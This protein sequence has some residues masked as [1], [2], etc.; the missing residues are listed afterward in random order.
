VYLVPE[1]GVK[2]V[3]VDCSS[4][5]SILSATADRVSGKSGHA[6]SSVVDFVNEFMPD[7]YLNSTSY[8]KTLK[9]PGGSFGD[10]GKSLYG[11]QISREVI[12]PNTAKVDKAGTIVIPKEKGFTNYI[13]SL[14]N[15]FS[16]FQCV[17]ED[18]DSGVVKMFVFDQGTYSIYPQKLPTSMYFGEDS[19]T[20]PAVYAKS[21][22]LATKEALSEATSGADEKAAALGERIGAVE[23]GVTTAK[24][25]ITA[26]KSNITE[27]QANITKAQGDIEAVTSEV[28]TVKTDVAALGEK[29]VRSVN[30][31]EPDENGNVEV[32]ASSDSSGK[33]DTITVSDADSAVSDDT[34]ILSGKSVENPKGLLRFAASKLWEY[35]QGKIAEVL[36]IKV[37]S[38]GGTEFLGGFEYFGEKISFP[39][40]KQGS[41]AVSGD[42]NCRAI[43]TVNF[44]KEMPTNNYI[45]D[46][47][48][49][50]PDPSQ[51][52]SVK[53]C[54][55]KSTG[56]K[57]D[58]ETSAEGEKSFINYIAVAFR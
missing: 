56:F 18:Y 47:G 10:L 33:N 55:K 29:A 21:V 32:A 19:Y 28:E 9:V 35:V 46:F 38:Y 31:T 41:F 14:D 37:T 48:E 43:K 23:S 12:P 8:K 2:R 57:V 40:V 25:D 27:A 39:F 51:V 3:D 49:A 5:E 36:G 54:E 7:E 4:V 6:I 44:A 53:V 13:V 15:C 1:S 26:M 17:N 30:G 11:V 42:K 58:I 20:P 52:V 45:L 24:A 50:S 16:F 22:E 34:G